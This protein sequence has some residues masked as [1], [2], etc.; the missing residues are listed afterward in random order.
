MFENSKMA[1]I[2][3]VT[4]N[5]NLLLYMQVYMSYWTKFTFAGFFPHL[6]FAR[7]SM[8]LNWKLK[9][10][11]VIVCVLLLSISYELWFVGT[12]RLSIDRF[13]SKDMKSPFMAMFHEDVQ[14]HVTD[15]EFSRR[16]FSV[17]AVSEFIVKILNN[18]HIMVALKTVC[19]KYLRDSEKLL[20]D[21]VNENFEK[22][23]DVMLKDILSK[24]NKNTFLDVNEKY[25]FNVINGT[26]TNIEKSLST[27]KGQCVLS[28]EGTLCSELK[29]L[30][31]VTGNLKLKKKPPNAWKEERSSTCDYM[32]MNSVSSYEIT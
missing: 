12:Q 22:E 10:C 27:R 29:T 18:E 15:A 21:S 11:S 4:T 14:M 19:K 24:K 20:S 3:M 32:D 6:E 8:R 2:A 23:A 5:N 13:V 30:N 28:L 9:C 7:V 31:S 16:V 17:E 26:C 1:V 25:E